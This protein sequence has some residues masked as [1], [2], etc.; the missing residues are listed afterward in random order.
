MYS[1]YSPPKIRNWHI[2]SRWLYGN[3]GQLLFEWF[4]L[5]KNNC[6]N[7]VEDVTI[8]SFPNSQNHDN[9][10]L[11]DERLVE[12]V[13]E[14]SDINVIKVCS[15]IGKKR[16]YCTNTNFFRNFNMFHKT[17]LDY[18]RTQIEGPQGGKNAEMHTFD[19]SVVYIH[20]KIWV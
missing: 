2:S 6:L 10:N 11:H 3:Q 16:W 19:Q 15:D 4:N 12:I 1:L 17:L 7:V 13:L 5:F 8:A 9:Q 20:V 18:E 14:R